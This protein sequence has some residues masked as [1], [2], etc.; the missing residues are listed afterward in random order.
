[1]L[2]YLYGS[3]AKGTSRPYSDVDIAVLLDENISVEEGPYGY[4]ATV[5]SKS[6]M[7]SPRR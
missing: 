3:S 1:M 5:T 2:A 4:R 6:L 7:M